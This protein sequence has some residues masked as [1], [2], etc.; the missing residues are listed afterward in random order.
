[1]EQVAHRAGVGHRAAV[2]GERHPDVG[3]GPV[4]VVGQ[5]L[6]E[7]RHPAGPVALVGDVLV[8]G[9]AGLLAAAPLDRP[10]DVVVRDRVLLR[11]LDRVVE[12]RVAGRVTTAGPRRDLN[13]LDQLGEQLAA[14]CVDHCLLVLS[15]G[16]LGVAAHR[17]SFSFTILRKSSWMRRSGVSSGWKAV[18]SSCPCRTAT[19]LPVWPSVPRTVTAPAASSTQGALMNTACTGLPGWVARLTSLSNESTWRP[20]A[21]LRTV[22]SIPP[23]VCWPSIPSEIRSASMII[24][25]HEPKAGMPSLRRLAMGSNR[26]NATASFHSVVDSPPGM[27]SPSTRSSSAGRR[28]AIAVAPASVTARACSGTSPWRAS[29]PITSW[30]TPR[31]PAAAGVV[32]FRR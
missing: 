23:N 18:A 2:A 3:C 7:N 13:V 8:L 24:P 12:G 29:T 32:L 16:P 5:A 31:L 19:I 10:V 27:I 11:L 20:N 26:S 21:F 14:L 30:V 9:A 17:A 6:H 25:A 15:G 4:A 22:M 1:V 28:T